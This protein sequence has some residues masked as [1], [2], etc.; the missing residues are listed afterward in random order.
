MVF[1]HPYK[2]YEEIAEFNKKST[3]LSLKEIVYVTISRLCNK[4]GRFIGP[5]YEDVIAYIES[6]YG[7]KYSRRSIEKAIEDLEREG[8][9][10]RMQGLLQDRRTVLLTTKE[11]ER[12][13]FTLLKLTEREALVH[14]HIWEGK[15]YDPPTEDATSPSIPSWWWMF[16]GIMGAMPL[17]SMT[18]VIGA[19]ELGRLRNSN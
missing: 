4:R 17:I 2:E 14:N 5:T 6:R 11:A 13:A 1:G 15:V 9:V 16:A 12:V 8:H 7:K 18:I 19:N 3:M 10:H